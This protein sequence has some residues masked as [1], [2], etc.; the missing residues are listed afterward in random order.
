MTN[1]TDLFGDTDDLRAILHSRAA[2]APNPDDLI[3][4]VR[5][6]A[7]RRRLRR[8]GALFGGVVV[9]TTLALIGATMLRSVEA[10]VIPSGPPLLP[11]AFPFSVGNLPDGLVPTGWL[12]TGSDLTLQPFDR[13]S[14][15]FTGPRAHATVQ[16]VNFDPAL[17]L[18]P[19]S[20]TSTLA[21]VHG[22]PAVVVTDPTGEF[23]SVSWPAAPGRWF[24]VDMQAQSVIGEPAVLAVADAVTATPSSPPTTLDIAH[25]PAGF[26]AFSWQQD[27]RA[28]VDDDVELCPTTM[29][30]AS[31]EKSCFTVVA[32]NGS[33]TIKR[34]F[35]GNFTQ[36]RNVRRIGSRG[37]AGVYP[38]HPAGISSAEID[39]LLREVSVG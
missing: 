25:L 28:G 4:A 12:S 35:F 22:A 24:A 16:Y 34:A 1:D 21:A 23:A 6:L 31:G 5:P 15:D 37:W 36:V 29:T 27:K 8:R 14:M 7:R 30:K 33:Q 20:Q 10:P 17:T 39:G 32:S 9:L 2:L 11:P 26:R 3:P 19:T 13:D 38:D 18:I